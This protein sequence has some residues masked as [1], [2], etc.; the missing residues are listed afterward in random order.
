MHF[1]SARWYDCI[2]SDWAESRAWEAV[3]VVARLFA[4]NLLPVTGELGG[5]RAC[6]GHVHRRNQIVACGIDAQ[7]KSHFS[8]RPTYRCVMSGWK[9]KSNVS[10]K[11]KRSRKTVFREMADLNLCQKLVCTRPRRQ[12]CNQSRRRRISGRQSPPEIQTREPTLILIYYL[13]DFPC[14]INWKYQEA[15]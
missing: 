7:K 4:S 6:G 1:T 9:W 2:F 14:F 12:R 15:V 8:F 10:A 3:F 13:Q 11:W 5:R